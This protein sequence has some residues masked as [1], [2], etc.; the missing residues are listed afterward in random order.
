MDISADIISRL[1]DVAISL[2]AV[3]LLVLIV[4]GL[5]YI[6]ILWLRSRN[7][8]KKSLD[9]VLLQIAVPHNN[10]IKIDAA[11]QIFSSLASLHKGGFLSFLN[12]QDHISFEIVG[13]PGDIRFYVSLPNKLRD[14]VEKQIYGSY[15]G[16]EMKEVDE[17][18]IFD[19]KGKVEF[20]SLKLKGADYLPIK[21]FK[22]LPV[23]PL[24]SLTS[25]LAKMGPGEGAAVQII[26]SPSDGKWKKNG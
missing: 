9:Y 25:A 17:Y 22:D 18:N 11:E 4:A 23:D 14:L 7:R 2:A 13:K 10:E 24:S 5:G 15:P 12:P 3:I 21:V 20:A 26:I 1:Q 6:F 16:A 19:D 8:E